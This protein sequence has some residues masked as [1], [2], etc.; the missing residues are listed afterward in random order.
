MARTGDAVRHHTEKRQ[1]RIQ[2]RQAESQGGK[3]LRHSTGVDHGQ[4]RNAELF[5]EIGAGQFAIEQPHHAFDQNQVGFASCLIQMRT[6]IGFTAH[7]QIEL[8]HGM[9]GS[10]LQ[11][12]GVD[13]IQPGLE[14][15]HTPSLAAVIG[16]KRGCD[17]GFP[18][19]RGGSAN[20]HGGTMA[21]GHHKSMPGWAR[22]PLR[23]ACLTSRISLTV[24]AISCRDWGAARPV[25]TTCCIGGRA[26]RS[27]QTC[28]A[29]R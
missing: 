14:Y 11:N 27:A 13:K 7:P 28:R 24:S 3:S 10:L 21:H 8:I 2:M 19:P 18:L 23:K 4:N 22:T 20:E 25:I 5:G 9:A 6:T 26:T 12:G 16:G 17:G 29:S 1:S 15:A